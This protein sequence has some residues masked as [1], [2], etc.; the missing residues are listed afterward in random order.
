MTRKGAKKSRP[1]KTPKK[2]GPVY[3]TLPTALGRWGGS[4]TSAQIDRLV[5]QQVEKPLMERYSISIHSPDKWR[6]LS[7]C[8]AEELGLISFAPPKSRRPQVWF[9]AG[10]LLV[11][12]MDAMI[13]RRGVSVQS[14]ASHLVNR[15]PEYKRLSSKSLVN[16]Y[17][18][19]KNKFPG[20]PLSS[21]PKATPEK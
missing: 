13:A 7:W 1:Q 10:R 20:T 3:V 15:Y 12:R 8:L 18:E 21:H 16:R 5:S 11:E 6:Y 9:G 14:A 17:N 4:L 2:S 19:S